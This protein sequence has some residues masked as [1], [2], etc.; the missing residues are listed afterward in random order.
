MEKRENFDK[1]SFF[2]KLFDR[3]EK[4]DEQMKEMIESDEYIK[5]LEDVT[6]RVGFVYDRD[7]LDIND[8]KNVVLLGK[9]YQFID[10]Y[11]QKNY[12]YPKIDG[13]E[14][15][16]TIKYRENNYSIGT[17][18]NA[19]NNNYYCAKN[20]DEKCETIDYEDLKNNIISDKA[21]TYKEKL[22]E[23]EE[24]IIIMNETIPLQAIETTC[25]N[26]IEKIKSKSKTK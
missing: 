15:I 19:H 9:F 2:D 20:I 12:I 26:T 11:A 8:M 13:S 10:I 16:Y 24:Y 5:W 7:K 6:N 25:N 14:I 22:K 23:L 21:K 17:I 3:W 4:E 1:K 18:I